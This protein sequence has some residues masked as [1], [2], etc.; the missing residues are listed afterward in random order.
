MVKGG[1]GFWLFSLSC[2]KKTELSAFPPK[3][4]PLL[5]LLRAVFIGE[6]GAGKALLC[7]GS[8]GHRARSSSRGRG[9]LSFGSSMQSLFLILRGAWGSGN[10]REEE[11]CQNDIVQFSLFFNF[12]KF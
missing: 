11:Q 12:F 9:A 5:Q 3:E 2:F 8:R 6:E 1:T 4:P 7:M 10:M